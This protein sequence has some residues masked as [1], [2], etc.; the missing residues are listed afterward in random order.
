MDPL[1]QK[2]IHYANI[3][4]HWRNYT[5]IFLLLKQIQNDIKGYADCVEIQKT[6]P[7]HKMLLTGETVQIPSWILIA[8]KNK[9]A[10]IK[11]LFN[12]HI[13]TVFNKNSSFQ[14]CYYKNKK[15]YGPGVCDAK[16][17]MVILLDA[18]SRYKKHLPDT[19]GWTI[20]L[21]ADEEIGSPSSRHILFSFAKTHTYGFVF[22]P[23]LPN[24]KWV[25]Q[26][27]SS[28]NLTIISHGK[29]G[30]AGR[31]FFKSRNAIQQLITFLS[32][33]TLQITCNENQII[34]IGQ[35]KGG[36]A[37]NTIPDIA[38][39]T[40]NIRTSDTNSMKRILKTIHESKPK[41]IKINV[42]SCRPPKPFDFKTKKLF[43]IA[44]EINSKLQWVETSGVCDGNLLSACNLP[45]IDT[46]GAIGKN[47]HTH[48]EYIEMDSLNEGSEFLIQ[49]IDRVVLKH[50]KLR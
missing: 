18:L 27:K 43:E 45:T 26:R 10:N 23:P 11:L 49:L 48:S 4:T 33:W 30:H 12:I 22:E 32:N 20:I 39:S 31:D 40:I 24:K 36:T 3:N 42:D 46:L 41:S 13:D 37:P 34:N 19:V 29:T 8:K 38:V 1:V 6:K 35:I 2:L 14:T 28:T 9:S 16:G 44:R 17:G 7:I 50:S 5:N 25:S 15:L 47:I 21:N